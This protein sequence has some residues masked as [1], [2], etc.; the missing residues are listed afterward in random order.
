MSNEAP[1]EVNLESALSSAPSEVA[2]FAD[3]D[4]TRD[5]VEA[6][7]QSGLNVQAGGKQLL[8]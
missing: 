5:F 7:E 3:Q 2:E 8:I 1:K 4:I 6:V